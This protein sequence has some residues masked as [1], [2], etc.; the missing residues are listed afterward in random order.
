MLPFIVW[1]YIR[2]AWI[3]KVS[4]QWA[5]T[6]QFPSTQNWRNF[7][8]LICRRMGLLT[9]PLTKKREELEKE[10]L[11]IFPINVPSTIAPTDLY[12]QRAMVL[13]AEDFNCDPLPISDVV[14][15]EVLYDLFEQNFRVELFALDRVEVYRRDLPEELASIRDAFVIDAF[16]RGVLI[17]T[18]IADES[19]SAS[20]LHHRAVCVNSFRR[21]LMGWGSIALP[22]HADRFKVD[23]SSSA[24][25]VTE[26]E[27]LAFPIY[28]NEFFR[29][30][31]RAPTVP[32]V[33]P[34]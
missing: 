7:I 5:P 28:C 4:T 29:W 9:A 17:G 34:L 21:V 10:I 6:D 31:G 27:N 8:F 14:R 12:W 1:L 15:R 22:L 11:K 3:S 24:E 16:P 32:H 13:K 18:D 30:F 19:V 26:L 33:R 20:D 2:A 25:V 23:G